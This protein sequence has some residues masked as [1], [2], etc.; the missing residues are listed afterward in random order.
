MLLSTIPASFIAQNLHFA[1]NLF[2]ALAC[3]TAGWLYLDAP[4]NHHP[5]AKVAKY[6]GFFTL[7]IGLLV[8]GA[9][10]QDAQLDLL[11]ELI[12]VVGYV[13]IIIGNVI[14][15]LQPQPKVTGLVMEPK[16]IQPQQHPASG[17]LAVPAGVAVKLSWLPPFGSLVVALLYWRRATLGLERHLKRVALAF[18]VLTAADLLA[19]THWWAQSDNPLLQ[20]LVQPLGSLWLLEHALLLLAGFLLLRWVWRYLTKQP[21]T[22]FF[23]MAMNVAG[24]VVLVAAW[25]I[26]G[27]LLSNLQRDSLANLETA[28]KVLGYAVNGKSADARANANILAQNG[29]VAGAVAASDHA[30]LITATTPLLSHQQFTETL[31]TDANGQVLLRASDP[32]RYNDSAAADPLVIRA[33]AGQN[34]S[35]LAAQSG[36]LAPS[37]V[38]ASASPVRSGGH[39]VGVVLSSQALDNAF[40]DGLK[41]STGLDSTVYSG[42]I[43]TATTLVGSDGSSRSIG[44]QESNPAV[45]ATTLRQGQIWSGPVT[46]AN[47]SFLAIYLPLKNANNTVVGMLSVA[48]PQSLFLQTSQQAIQLTF[49]SSIICLLLLVAPIYWVARQI[50]RQLGR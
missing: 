25:G 19:L 23:L 49:I 41:T 35:G 40:V 7:A 3:F 1:V 15:P 4:S 30:A 37:L 10:W 50:S 12:K 36:A 26:T 39:V 31:L 48:E 44:A 24:A 9:S 13:V 33:L 22:Q 21:T 11:A 43:R 46:L 20:G 5:I 28:T 14:E 8:S 34:A 32:E 6:S 18:A 17:W 45:I 29:D 42:N 2:V 27:A 16:V 38:I 47:R